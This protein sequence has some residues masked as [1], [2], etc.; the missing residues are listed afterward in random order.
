V[1]Y[2]DRL[3]LQPV[4]FDPAVGL[5]EAVALGS[6]TFVEARRV[7]R[8]HAANG[9][10]GCCVGPFGYHHDACEAELCSRCGL[11]LM[12][13]C[14]CRRP[15]DDEDEEIFVVRPRDRVDNPVTNLSEDEIREL[16]GD[17]VE[18]LNVVGDFRRRGLENAKTAVD[19]EAR[20]AEIN[21]ILSGAQASVVDNVAVRCREHA[22]K[23]DIAATALADALADALRYKRSVN[24]DEP[25]AREMLAAL[26]IVEIGDPEAATSP[27]AGWTATA[28]RQGLIRHGGGLG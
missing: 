9:C 7:Y 5:F 18:A 13:E 8:R 22:R 15:T 23:I 3:V 2:A 6:M 1:P 25:G 10:P 27:L 26:E 17:R 24:T 16:R 4:P 20:I 28:I 21:A 11:T 14:Q 19:A 12:R